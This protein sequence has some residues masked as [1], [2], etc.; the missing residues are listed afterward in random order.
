MHGKFYGRE[1]PDAERAFFGAGVDDLEVVKRELVF[2]VLY[3]VQ[4]L[5]HCDVVLNCCIKN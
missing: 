5:Q 2:L 3:Q 1:G 4:L